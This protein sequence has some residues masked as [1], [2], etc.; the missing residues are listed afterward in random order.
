MAPAKGVR[1]IV[2]AEIDVEKIPARLDFDL[3]RAK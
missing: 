2:T 1:V 3:L